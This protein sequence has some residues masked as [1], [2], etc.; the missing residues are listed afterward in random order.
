MAEMDYLSENSNVSVAEKDPSPLEEDNQF[1]IPKRKNPISFAASVD[2]SSPAGTVA[3]P[4]S[5]GNGGSSS[6]TFVPTASTQQ[7]PIMQNIPTR[8]QPYEAISG[9][10][11]AEM[12]CKQPA[13]ALDSEHRPIQLPNFQ[14]TSA[15]MWTG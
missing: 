5:G 11:A 2:G 4:T 6:K 3:M 7:Q 1:T 8:P 10:A 15:C 14:D 12:D 9:G 13:L